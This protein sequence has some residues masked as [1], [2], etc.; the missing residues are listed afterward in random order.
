L[1][2]GAT[3]VN[4]PPAVGVGTRRQ[5]I[6]EGFDRGRHGTVAASATVRVSRLLAGRARAGSD[7]EARRIA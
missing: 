5:G 7:I 1:T 3:A 6:L 4:F 2:D